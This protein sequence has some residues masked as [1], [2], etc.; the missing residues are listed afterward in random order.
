METLA[1]NGVLTLEEVYQVAVKR[2][3][4]ALDARA[5]TRMEK[6]RQ[7]VEDLILQK[8]IVYGV[9]T[10]FGRFSDVFI[11]QQKVEKLQK[12]L[13]HSH[14]IG[15]GEPLSQEFV[16]G[17][18][19][20]RANA[21][22][23]G[24]SGIRPLVVQ[25]LLSMLNGYIHPVIPCKGSVG[26]SGDLIPLSYMVLSMMGEG[27]VF[28]KGQR[29]PSLTALKEAR[30]SP[31][32]LKGKEGLALIN[33]TQ[34]MASIG[35]LTLVKAQQLAQL[36]DVA[37]AMSFTALEGLQPAFDPRIH[38]LRPHPGQVLVARRMDLLTRD[39]QVENGRREVQDPYTLRCIPQIHGASRDAICHV[40]DIFSREINAVT[41]NPLFFPGENE[42]LS[43]GNFHG[44]PLALGLDYLGL[45]LSELA[46]VSER[47]IE[48]LVN[49]SLSGL[50]AFLT[51]EGGLNS[52]FMIAQY[53]AA[54]L[55]S[56]NK[57]L[58]SPASVDSIPT[59]GNKEDHVSMGAIAARKAY[60]ILE[61]LEAV[62]AIEFLCG[63]QA[64]DLKENCTLQPPLSTVH[65]LIREEIPFL[66]EDRLL[67]QDLE[68]MMKLLD[69][70]L[71][72]TDTF[73]HEVAVGTGSG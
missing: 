65:G 21:L 9:T 57:V 36:A 67:Y 61:H 43:G 34:A 16:R 25:L 47:R 30:L 31:V 7:M 71:L 72:V 15:V 41:D 1:I 54:A 32:V 40:Q 66:E 11:D 14:C 26:A 59:S 48:R 60:Q 10:G 20:L 13:I 8:E 56:E 29:V 19:L 63:A 27:E 38:A 69:M 28:Y 24:S 23:I 45:A 17:M 64:L 33:G 49:P 73:F 39:C 58:S 12:N 51:R 5:K 53:T 18:M 70:I 42:V 6:S 4:V 2:R 46:N 22:S 35:A 52:G 62:L 3:P 68:K 44:Q 55:V 37:A 50:P